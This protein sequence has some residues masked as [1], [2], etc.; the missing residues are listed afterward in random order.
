MLV[1]NTA[2]A[3]TADGLGSQIFV[4]LHY[5]DQFLVHRDDLLRKTDV[6]CCEHLNCGSIISGG[7]IKVGNGVHSFLLDILVEVLH[8]GIVGGMVYRALGSLLRFVQLLIG[9]GEMFFRMRPGLIGW[10][11]AAPHFSVVGEHA[12]FEYE[13]VRGGDQFLCQIMIFGGGRNVHGVINFL[14]ED[15]HRLIHVVIGAHPLVIF[16]KIP[17]QN[18][19]I[20]KV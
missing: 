5:F 7:G 17:I 10:V 2:N 20:S 15:L 11:A 16:L 9:I 14:N 4:F 3:E 1:L 6:G 13:V 18:F 19:H 8:G 12:G